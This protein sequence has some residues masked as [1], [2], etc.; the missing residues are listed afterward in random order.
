MPSPVFGAHPV[1]AT[2]SGVHDLAAASAS[3]QVGRSARCRAA[4]SCSFEAAR[5]ID[6]GVAAHRAS[7]DYVIVREDNHFVVDAAAV[8]HKGRA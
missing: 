6:H 2:L 4:V 5:L 8:G 1:S 7:S 3:P